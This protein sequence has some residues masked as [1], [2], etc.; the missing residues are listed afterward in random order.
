MS[1]KEKIE[2]LVSNAEFS[3]GDREVF[4][5]FRLALRSG[6]IRSALKDADGNWHANTWVKQG[7]LLG[8]RMGKMVE[9]SKSTETFQFFDKDTFPLRPM[10]LEDKVRIV[11]G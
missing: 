5:E 1:L 2:S 6:E 10:S 11:I 8:F 9:M 4:E 7:I 3:A